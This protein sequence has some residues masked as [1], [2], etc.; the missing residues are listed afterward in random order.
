MVDVKNDECDEE[1]IRSLQE[2]LKEFNQK[3]NRFQFDLASADIS[4]FYQQLKNKGIITPERKYPR[5][6][7]AEDLLR[8]I[9]FKCLVGAVEAYK[10]KS[11]LEL[12]TENK[13]NR[14]GL[15]LNN[16]CEKHC[17][18]C[19]SKATRQG[20]QLDYGLVA[21]LDTRYWG[22]FKNIA[23]GLEGEPFYYQSKGKDLGG[24]VEFLIQQG[25]QKFSFLTGGLFRHNPLYEKV[26][27]KLGA[28]KKNGVEYKFEI[29][30][31]HYVSDL[32]RNSQSL[33]YTLQLLSN[34]GDGFTIKV[35]GD[36]F[37]GSTN[38]RE[39]ISGL[40][41]LLQ[42][43][44]FI[45]LEDALAGEIGRNEVQ[46]RKVHAT[47]SIP[48]GRYRG[49]VKTKP[50]G[51]PRLC[52][53]LGYDETIV[54]INGGVRFCPEIESYDKKTVSNIYQKDFEE[55]MEDLD[56]FHKENYLWLQDR[57]PEIMVGEK[58]SCMCQRSC[59]G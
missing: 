48:M 49:K 41:N 6:L 15:S 47:P 37:P 19:A 18:N 25:L 14:L 4:S 8:F 46:I 27:E 32:E 53:H 43:H 29:T 40:D 23:F 1:V 35:V 26:V 51:L 54:D 22:L 12:L 2:H 31:N 33:L 17:S 20:T 10:E 44:G 58:K 16:A 24:V 13:N 38:L 5:A 45:A 34:L 36:E 55:V 59:Y 42:R 11:F 21:G 57:L 3:Y 56:H 9:D 52:S 7:N 28:L 50:E 30:Y 39:T